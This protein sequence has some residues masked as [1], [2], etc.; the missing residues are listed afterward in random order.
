MRYFTKDKNEGLELF[1]H[2]IGQVK[3]QNSFIAL[4]VVV[5]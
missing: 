2:E 1:A 4:A 3:S 5:Q